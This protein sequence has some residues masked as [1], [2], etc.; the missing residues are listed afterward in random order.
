[1]IRVNLVGG[2]G[3]QLFQYYA[4]LL[5]ANGDPNRLRIRTAF[6]HF[7]ITGHDS[8]IT[9][10]GLPGAFL[11]S[12][13]DK[14]LIHLF[15][16]AN[17]AVE[18]RLGDL[19]N[20]HPLVSRMSRIFKSTELGYDPT[21]EAQSSSRHLSI[22]GYFQTWKYASELQAG[23]LFPRPYIQSPTDWFENQVSTQNQNKTLALHIRR[24]DYVGSPLFG[25]LS[26]D[27]YLAAI[28]RL[29]TQGANWD[30]VDIYSDEPY[31]IRSEFSKLISQ[32]NA[33]VASAPVYSH[34]GETLLAMAEADYLVMA[35]STFSWWSGY[36]AKRAQLIVRPEK[37][38]YGMNDPKDL[39][40]P[41]WISVPSHWA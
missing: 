13:S 10:L 17:R 1:M 40:E 12:N 28:K 7:A 11:E 39:F 20:Q 4:G 18:E 41:T 19:G 31:R 35:N 14:K 16:L 32:E 8:S 3:N 25:T 30:R 24:G 29:R 36:L 33:S 27:Y 15:N 38:F 2:L 34:P 26:Q 22:W 21:L 23:G 9:D 37:W 5:A 6:S